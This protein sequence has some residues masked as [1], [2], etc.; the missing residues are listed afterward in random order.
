[1]AGGWKREQIVQDKG[2]LFEHTMTEK[3][4]KWVDRTKQW[5]LITDVSQMSCH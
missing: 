4:A 3:N 5:T 1:M 2:G